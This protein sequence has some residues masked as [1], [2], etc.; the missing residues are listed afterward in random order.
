MVP[1]GFGA[2]EVFLARDDGPHRTVAIHHALAHRRPG[3]WGDHPSRPRSI[4]LVREV[5]D[6]CDVFG[7]G[8]AEPAVAWLASQRRPM[9]LLAPIDWEPTVR[10][11]SGRIERG[12]VQTWLRPDDRIEGDMPV[13]DAIADYDVAPDSFAHPRPAPVA[14]TRRLA[15]RDVDAFRDVT[16]DWALW[17][18]G[19]FPPLI[20]K[21]A[22]FGVPTKDGRL[23]S[24][25]W[26]FEEGAAHDKIGVATDPRYQR[27][28]L[29][30]AAATALIDHVVQDRH[31]AP[32]W[33]AATRNLA[34]Q[35]IAKSLGFSVQITETILKW[36]PRS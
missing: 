13:I 12:F 17:G 6:R 10:R 23:A 2:T 15:D 8:R 16:P 11:K 32:L 3:L 28:G 25:A 33:T 35:S 1:L 26:I 9:N 4:L 21:A 7:A 24:V 5:A 34:S 36:S 19:S 18:W 20:A 29:G 27:L 22:A 31:K 14:P 30:R